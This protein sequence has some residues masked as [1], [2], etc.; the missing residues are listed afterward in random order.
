[1]PPIAPSQEIDAEG[2]FSNLSPQVAIAY[3]LQPDRM[4]YGAIAR[5]F[6]AGGFNAASP[7]GFQA[8][9][10][11]QTWNL[12]GGVKT[13]W[14]GGRVI[15]NAALFRIDW[16]DLQLN[17]PNPLVPA[18]FYIANVG[19]AV[20]TGAE[21]EI[22][23][24]LRDGLEVFSAIGFTSAEFEA[25]SISSGMSVGGNEIP[26]TPDYTATFG[27]QVS[28]ALETDRTIYGRAETTFYG[29]F[30][31]DDLNR[32]GQE[33]YSLTNLRAGIRAGSLF[34]EAWVRNAFDTRYVPVALP[35]DPAL[36]PSGF[37][38]EMGAPRT[39]GINAGVTF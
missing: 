11:E 1:V 3:R 36:A 4:V 22:D 34:A 16:D 35:F 30:R 26:N 27:A 23:A 14:R 7:P 2:N 12:E 18:Q 5:G 38:G 32:A 28:R 21:L 19:G 17:L 20:S 8:Y 24:R 33:A 39:F 31:Y 29:A 37:L 13:A 25:G 15:A 10:E 6:K 9:G